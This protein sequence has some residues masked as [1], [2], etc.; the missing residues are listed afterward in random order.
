MVITDR[1]I[2]AIET[3]AHAHK[4]Q[5]RTGTDIPYISHPYSVALICQTYSDDEDIFIAA[6][7]HDVIE[8]VSPD[9]CSADDIKNL[10][11]ERVLNLIQGVSEVKKENGVNRPWK[12]RKIDY[13]EHLKIVDIGVLS[14]FRLRTS[15]TTL[16][17]R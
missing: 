2:K 11:G 1:I 16:E 14:L 10:F 7:L 3:S 8:D 17:A 15:Y 13:I 12:D 9:I 4:D 5:K 6:L